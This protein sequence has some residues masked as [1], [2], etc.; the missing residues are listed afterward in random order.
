MTW[1]AGRLQQARVRS[2]LGRTVR[3]RTDGPVRVVGPHGPVS[4]ERPEDGLA[5]FETRRGATYV[6]Q[7]T[8]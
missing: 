2:P 4:V 8:A 1:S 6:V 7:P 3:L 5:V